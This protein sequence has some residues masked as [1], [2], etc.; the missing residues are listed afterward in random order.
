MTRIAGATG[1]LRRWLN[2]TPRQLFF[3][4]AILLLAA[5]LRILWVLYAAREPQALNDPFFYLIYGERIANGYGYTI[6]VGEVTSAFPLGNPS[7]PTAYYPVGYPASLGAVFFLV[8]HALVPDNLPRTWGFFQVFL[9]VATVGL[10]FYVGRRLFGTVTGA[11]AALWIALFPNLIFHTGAVLSE[12]LFNFL[13]MGFLAVLVGSTWPK[14]E[15]SRERLVAAGVLLGAAALVRPIALLLLPPLLVCWLVAGAR[16]QRAAVQLGLVAIATIAVIMPWT[17]RNVIVMEAPIV[18]SA[19]LGDDLCMGHHPGAKGHFALPDHCFAGYDQ[20]ERPEYEVRRNDENTRKAIKF[21]VHNPIAEV[22]LL[23]A[24]ARYLWESDHDALSA[25]ESYGHDPFIDPALRTA[26]ART[27]DI[28]FF[29]TISIGGLG[30]IGL[31]VTRR[32]PRHTFLV[33]ATL[34]F[35]G[36]PLVFFGDSRFHV[37]AMPLLVLAASWAT[38][39]ALAATANLFSRSATGQ[40]HGYESQSG[41][42]VPERERPVVEQDAL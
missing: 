26:L 28:Y 38:V 18:I 27:A 13:T 22:K 11:L 21:A 7:E 16:W 36:I 30:L 10:A 31:L 33:L 14:G 41:V 3:L 29:I 17:I 5:A 2:L 12:T 39:A 40:S 32:D 24:K 42:E 15:L 8:E 9:G 1:R 35:A 6:P 4:A 23:S 19:N 25:V 20:Y 37:P 34:A